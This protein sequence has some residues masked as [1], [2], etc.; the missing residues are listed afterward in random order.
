MHSQVD[1]S[2]VAFFRNETK[3]QSKLEGHSV[4][5]IPPPSPN[6]PL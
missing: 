3:E 1:C 5:R 4:E 6:S 2:F